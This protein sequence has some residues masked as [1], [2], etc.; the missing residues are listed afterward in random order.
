MNP[1]VGVN[2]TNFFNRELFMYSLGDI[3][4]K[5]PVSLKKVAYTTL[6]LIFYTIPMFVIFGLQLS[7]FFFAL[8]FGPPIIAGHYSTKPAFG[9]KTLPQFVGTICKFA[10]EPKGWTDLNANPNI[11]E[12]EVLFIESEIWISRRR[13]LRLLADIK[14]KSLVS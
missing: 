14:D 5:K 13:E 1:L 11:D 2:M 10:L 4:F 12:S 8:A 9:G 3:R 7:I 6:F